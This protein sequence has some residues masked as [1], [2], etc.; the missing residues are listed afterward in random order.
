M[1]WKLVIVTC[2]LMLALATPL[3][4]SPYC[5]I[6]LSTSLGEGRW[7]VWRVCD[8]PPDGVPWLTADSETEF[9][10]YW[11]LGFGRYVI[12]QI[13]QGAVL[14]SLSMLLLATG[15][16]LYRRTRRRPGAAHV[17][18]DAAESRRTAR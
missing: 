3:K 18:D 16:I 8:V 2:C 11:F 13:S 12:V 5:D 9:K 6:D 14:C 15:T 1:R 17:V 10:T 7:G 4:A